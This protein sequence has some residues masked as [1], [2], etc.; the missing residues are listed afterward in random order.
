MTF[1]TTATRPGWWILGAGFTGLAACEVLAASGHRVRATATSEHRASALRAR[2]LAAH[3]WRSG[4]PLPAGRAAEGRASR[5]LLTFGPRR[6]SDDELAASV[7]ACAAQGVARAYYLSSTSVFAPADGAWI[8]DTTPVAPSTAMGEARV[9]A[10]HAFWSA[11]DESGVQG[12]ALRLPGIY[13]VGRSGRSRFLGGAYRVPAGGPL[14]TNR[15]EAREVARAV[16]A[17]EASDMGE[18]ASESALPRALIVADGA[19]FTIRVYADWMCDALALERLP[20]TP[21]AEVPERSRP[22]FVGNR[23]CRPSVLQSLG[24]APH[25]RTVFDGLPVCW[26]KEDAA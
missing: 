9:R 22:F 26:A 8:D 4:A 16:L 23:R 20:D 2:G 18:V 6:A 10:E 14:Y 21:W 1:E 25:F 17:L 24:W 3:V 11:C 15:I 12:V 5:A 13:G 7:R 19:P